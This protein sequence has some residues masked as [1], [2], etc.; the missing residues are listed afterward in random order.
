M[1]DTWSRVLS[2]LVSLLTIWSIWIQLSMPFWFSQLEV[3]PCFK[4]TH[5]YSPTLPIFWKL[6]QLL[7]IGDVTLSRA[8]SNRRSGMLQVRLNFHPWHFRWCYQAFPSP[9]QRPSKGIFTPGSNW[10]RLPEPAVLTSLKPQRPYSK[11][12]PARASMQVLDDSTSSRM[13]MP[14]E[15]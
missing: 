1:W 13:E 15:V 14:T 12:D 3:C 4:L 5:L 6:C 9:L 8:F 7:N 11:S 2:S 10:V